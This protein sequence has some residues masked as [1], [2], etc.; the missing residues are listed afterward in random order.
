MAK[1][2]CPLIIVDQDR[3]LI[4]TEHILRHTEIPDGYVHV[5]AIPPKRYPG[6]EGEFILV[7]AKRP[8]ARPFLKAAAEIGDVEIATTG[9]YEGQISILRELG[10]FELVGEVWGSQASQISLPLRR[11]WVLTDD[12]PVEGIVDKEGRIDKRVRTKLSWFGL[13]EDLPHWICLIEEHFIQW[14]R[15][16][17]PGVDPVS[18]MGLI[19]I[20][21]RKLEMQKHRRRL[22]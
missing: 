22:W 6:Y 8:S 16:E 13:H 20:I 12:H 1:Y 18:L 15:W 17:T 9:N 4:T 19:P 14:A 21:E 7:A 10:L 3:F 11:H 2:R 5:D